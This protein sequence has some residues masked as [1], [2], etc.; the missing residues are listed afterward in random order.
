MIGLYIVVIIEMF[1]HRKKI[2]KAM[3]RSY[4]TQGSIVYEVISRAYA[5]QLTDS[6]HNNILVAAYCFASPLW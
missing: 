1:F 3:L 4:D 5:I 2:Q 6:A